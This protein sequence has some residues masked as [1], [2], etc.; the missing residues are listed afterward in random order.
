MQEPGLKKPNHGGEKA[1][2]IVSDQS[3]NWMMRSQ[4]RVAR[5]G[6]EIGARRDGEQREAAPLPLPRDH[7]LRAELGRL[8]PEQPQRRVICAPPSGFSGKGSK[9]GE[10]KRAAAGRT[11]H[12]LELFFAQDT[13]RLQVAHALEHCV[14]N[15]LAKAQSGVVWWLQSN[16]A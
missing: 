5:P 6:S 13:E 4:H 15:H 12:L 9:Q 8:Q 3:S 2:M 14:Q 11:R 7:P 1:T 16:G 10:K